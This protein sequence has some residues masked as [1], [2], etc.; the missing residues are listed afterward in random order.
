MEAIHT[1]TAR[2][3]LPVWPSGMDE[4]GY[5]KT[6]AAAIGGYTLDKKMIKTP[7]HSKNGFEPLGIYVP[8]GILVHVKKG[9]GSDAISH[10]LVDTVG[11]CAK[12][13]GC[14]GIFVLSS[15]P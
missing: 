13:A 14:R 6:A 15:N 12:S 7:L 10:L 1:Q 5:N 4:D 2:I 9:L 3:T 11:P 8:P